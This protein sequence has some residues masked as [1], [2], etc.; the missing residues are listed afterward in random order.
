M[1]ASLADRAHTALSKGQSLAAQVVR[2]RYG[3]YTVPSQTEPGVRWTVI[4]LADGGL[5]CTCTAGL[6]G[7][8]CAHAAAVLVRRQREE[9]RRQRLAQA[10]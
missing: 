4:Q 3:V 2:V 1:S 6:M 8:P 9:K 7:K 5:Q 10:A